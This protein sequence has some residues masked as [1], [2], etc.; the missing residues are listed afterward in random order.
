LQEAFF[1]AGHNIMKLEAQLSST[2][3]QLR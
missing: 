3:Q 2:I 1:R